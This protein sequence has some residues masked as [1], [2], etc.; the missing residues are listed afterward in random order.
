V[1]A[2]E[3]P[4]RGGQTVCL[5]VDAH[6]PSAALLAALPAPDGVVIPESHCPRAAQQLH[7]AVS[8]YRV[9][10][11]AASGT[12]TL[13][14]RRGVALIASHHYEVRPEGTGWRVIEPLQ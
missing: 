3:L 5:S 13:A 12:I 8:A 11:G 7:L 9:K 14:R 2:G 4:S 10:P 6:D 1:L